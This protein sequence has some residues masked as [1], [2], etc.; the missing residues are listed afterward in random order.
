MANVHQCDICGKIMKNHVDSVC[1][2]YQYVSHYVG[3]RKD[4]EL[5]LCADCYSALTGFLRARE[6]SRKSLSDCDHSEQEE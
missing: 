2:L 3:L 5:D 4:K 1:I 6:K